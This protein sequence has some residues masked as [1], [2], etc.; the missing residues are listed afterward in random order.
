MKKTWFAVLFTLFVV[1]L[2]GI[3]SCT[4]SAS[5]STPS[6]SATQPGTTTPS[7]ST[8]AFDWSV[9]PVYPG[10]VRATDLE[11]ARQ[12]GQNY[13]IY[14]T[15]VANVGKVID[16]FKT[17]LTANGWHTVI[18]PGSNSMY[19]TNGTNTAG[20]Q[21]TPDHTDTTRCFIEITITPAD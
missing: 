13:R 15:D 7:V 14:V 18:P 16:Y 10:S 17:A 3:T 5:S 6:T 8:A 2:V 19:I 11:A 9:I 4:K 1:S 20:I 12:A 21:V